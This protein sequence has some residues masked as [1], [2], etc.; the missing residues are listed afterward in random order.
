MHESLVDAGRVRGHNAKE[1]LDVPALLGPGRG[2]YSG[3]NYVGQTGFILRLRGAHLVQIGISVVHPNNTRY[4][5]RS[6]IEQSL[7]NVD[8]SAELG[9]DGGKGSAE[10]VQ[11]PVRDIN[12]L[13]YS[14]L[15]VGPSVV[16]SVSAKGYV[17]QQ[18]Q[19]LGT[20]WNRVSSLVLG[21]VGRDC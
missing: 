17:F 20:D 1:H 11:G 7:G 4:R 16:D 8:R 3:S 6:V 21:N 15:S 9:V 5:T 13:V 14:P 12:V 18:T 2:Q 19:H 10:V